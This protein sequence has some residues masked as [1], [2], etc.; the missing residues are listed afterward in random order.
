LG[1]NHP[2]VL[3]RPNEGQAQITDDSIIVVVVMVTVVADDRGRDGPRRSDIH[4]AP[5][6]RRHVI[7]TSVR[8]V[9]NVA[10]VRPVIAPPAVRIVGSVLIV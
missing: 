8:I 6:N 9:I 2:T 10:A 1:R 7:G 3:E 4:S 5:R